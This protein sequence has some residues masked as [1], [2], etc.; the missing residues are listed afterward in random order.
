MLQKLGDHIATALARAKEFE[1][2]ACRETNEAAQARLL[3][4]AEAWRHVADSYQFVV[5][6]EEFLIDA[7][8]SGGLVSLDQ[9]R[10]PPKQRRT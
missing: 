5:K 8:K 6:L 10:T 4:L 2:L 7:H 1:E 9:L 3:K